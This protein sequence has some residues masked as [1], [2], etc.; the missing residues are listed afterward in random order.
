MVQVAESLAR[1]FLMPRTTPAAVRFLMLRTTPAAVLR[2][3]DVLRPIAG[4]QS[5]HLVIQAQ[6]LLLQ[7]NRFY[8]F[9]VGQV[10]LG[11]ELFQLFV[12]LGVLSGQDAKLFAGRHQVRFEF[13]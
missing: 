5:V 13:I 7:A 10:V 8:L 1:L 4:Q 11:L 2:S 3:G 12:Q 6:L 9:R